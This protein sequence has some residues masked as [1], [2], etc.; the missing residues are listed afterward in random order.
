MEGELEGDYAAAFSEWRG[1]LSD[2]SWL[3]VGKVISALKAGEK[4]EEN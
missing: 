2:T 4:T 3:S 1:L